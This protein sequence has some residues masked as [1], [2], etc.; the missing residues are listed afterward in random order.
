MF[1]H[2]IAPLFTKSESQIIKLVLVNEFI[3][4][5]QVDSRFHH[6]LNHE[7]FNERVVIDFGFNVFADLSFEE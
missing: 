1:L 7:K 5:V 6:D 4:D 3:G 2:A